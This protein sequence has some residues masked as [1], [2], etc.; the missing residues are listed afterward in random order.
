[1]IVMK[2]I[3]EKIFS[4]FKLGFSLYT[5]EHYIDTS[6]E[7]N[8]LDVGFGSSAP[9][10]TVNRFPK[11]NYYGIDIVDHTETPEVQ[12]YAKKFYKKDLEDADFKDI[13]ND[14]FDV[15]SMS[16]V[17]EHISNGVEVIEALIPKLKKGG[18]IYI[19]FPGIKSTKLPRASKGTLNFYDDPGHIKLYSMMEI[20]NI[21]SSKN[22]RFINGGKRK[23]LI[24]IM[25][26]PIVPFYSLYKFGFVDPSVFWDLLGFAEYCV[27]ERNDVIN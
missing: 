16:H 6:T 23:R 24:H 12:K 17:I 19:E 9:A 20:Y 15:I 25:M 2:T 26:M 10:N 22:M 27:F 11:V 5:I 3:S 7:I 8:F 18:I 4:F 14:F 1:M 13:P 21:L